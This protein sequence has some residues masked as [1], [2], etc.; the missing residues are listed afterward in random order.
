MHLLEVLRTNPKRLLLAR[1]R[2]RLVGEGTFRFWSLRV[3]LEE[4]VRR[5]AASIDDGALVLDAGAGE[6][7]YRP[8]F[9]HATYESADFQQNE[10]K[11]YGPITY[12]CDLVSIPVHPDRYDLVL[13]T[14]VLEH[15]PEP[16]LVLT[17]FFRV[18]KP[19]GRLWLS[20]HLYYPEHDAPYDFFRY[21]QYGLRHLATAA[22]FVVEE[23]EPMEGYYGTLSVQFKLASWALP[24]RPRYYGGGVLGW[25]MLPVATL[26]RPLFL[27]LWFLF[28]QLDIRHR[29]V[30]TGHPL[31]YVVVAVKPDRPAGVVADA[32]AS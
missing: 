18:L 9:A 32:G 30:H 26:L 13:C 29:H 27:V 15:V 11:R 20:T 24:R 3:H 10:D 6:G 22:G 14:Q 8:L 5:A 28:E 2:P 31:N 23:V 16:K 19:G 4:F 17:E 7:M 12:I 1:L 21:T 25:M